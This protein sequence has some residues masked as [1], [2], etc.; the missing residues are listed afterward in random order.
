[1]NF[2]LRFDVPVKD[3]VPM[4]VVDGFQELEHVVFDASLRK[5]VST[6][7]LQWI[8]LEL[9]YRITFDCIVEIHVHQFENQS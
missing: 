4:H 9:L 8:E 5:V 1:M 2:P 3:T 7:Y 6:A